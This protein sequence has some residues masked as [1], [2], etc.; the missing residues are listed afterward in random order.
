MDHCKTDMPDMA[1]QN[2]QNPAS[3]RVAPQIRYF[4][5]NQTTL[6]WLNRRTCKQTGVAW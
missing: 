6:D 3:L 4:V 1:D 2:R 5:A